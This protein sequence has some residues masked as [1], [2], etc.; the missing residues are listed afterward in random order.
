MTYSLTAFFP[1]RVAAFFLPFPVPD[2]V[3]AGASGTLA[4]AA[5]IG[6]ALF[7]SWG[8]CGRGSSQS[9]AGA[10][11]AGDEPK[12]GGEDPKRAR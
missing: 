7:T 1:F 9:S 8:E 10:S 3:L 4:P 11:E 2:D 6:F 5:V 12:G